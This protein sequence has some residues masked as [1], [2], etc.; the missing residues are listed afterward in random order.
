[1]KNEVFKKVADD[2]KEMLKSISANEFD[3]TWF[4]VN[5]KNPYTKHTYKG[6][7]TVY[8]SYLCKK[9]KYNVNK[10]LTFNE[11]K[12]LGATIQKGAKASHIIFYSLNLYLEGKL[13][14]PEDL[15]NLMNESGKTAEELGV[16]RKPILK[17]YPVFN[18]SLINGLPESYY[19]NDA[20]NAPEIF[21]HERADFIIQNS[22]ANIQYKF[23]ND[24]YYNRLGDYIGMPLKEQFKSVEGFY[25]TLFHELIHWTGAPERLNRKKGRIF[26]DND[27]AFEELV[28]EL[29]SCFICAQLGIKNEKREF[30]NNAAYL[31]SWLSALEN[32]I[33]FFVKASQY[34]EKAATFLLDF[35]KVANAA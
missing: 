6:F 33:T 32:D 25:S 27:Y 14:K 2:L 24:A 22:G 8:L 13:I 29:G 31:K 5:S 1:M 15:A 10:W 19:N 18:C 11:V 20:L 34:A 4:L 17:I 16:K 21:K 30:N 28:A 12:E 9:Y 35:E 23:N 26:G 7:N 3:Y